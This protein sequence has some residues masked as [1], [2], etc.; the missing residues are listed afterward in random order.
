MNKILSLVVAALLST[1]VIAGPFES[2]EI[3]RFPFLTAKVEIDN[4]TLYLLEVD[5][6]DGK[7]IIGKCNA[8]FTKADCET[9]FAN[10]FKGTMESLGYTVGSVVSFKFYDLKTHNPNV[11]IEFAYPGDS[12]EETPVE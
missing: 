2:F 11:V 10:D 8:Q 12:V 9:G 7:E 5:G 1:S 4:Q 3:I 6:V